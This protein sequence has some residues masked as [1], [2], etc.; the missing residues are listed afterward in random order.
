M[1]RQVDGVNDEVV[2]HRPGP[3]AAV[4][5]QLRLGP[6]TRSVRRPSRPKDA[7]ETANGTVLDKETALAEWHDMTPGQQQAAWAELRAWVAWLHDRYE[8]GT[9]DRLPR[10]WAR[11]PGLVEELRALR[12]WRLEIYSGSQP[13]GQATRYWHAELRQL[14]HSAVPMYA[15]GCRTGH[16][17]ASML[18]ADNLE[19]AEEW[20]SADPLAG[21]PAID[22]AAGQARLAGE[23]LSTVAVA[24]AF[25][26][27]DAS[28]VPLVRDYIFYAGAWWV[29]ASSGWVKVA[30]PGPVRESFARGPRSPETD[31]S[32]PGTPH[33]PWRG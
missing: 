3:S 9:E 32:A 27:G 22:I 1:R 7:S 17:G 23:C 19:L 13:S 8:L 20:A 15:A 6:R 24:A 25:D 33:D 28:A 4:R 10:C 16:R 14:V 31:Y 5:R 26:S 2:G 21:T 11:H 18:V 12:A 30:R 29:P